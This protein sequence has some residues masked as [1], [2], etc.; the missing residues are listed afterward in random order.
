[1]CLILCLWCTYALCNI[2]IC[3]SNAGSLLLSKFLCF[4]RSFVVVV[5]LK[6]IGSK[7]LFFWSS[8]GFMI[9]LFLSRFFYFYGFAMCIMHL[10][11]VL[12]ALWF[13][14][15]LVQFLFILHCIVAMNFNVF[16][17]FVWKCIPWVNAW[18]NGSKTR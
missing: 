11:V 3:K 13:H 10:F 15:V 17:L 7:V 1:M 5:L 18:Y 9:L 8:F 6:K 2:P 12:F 4:C 16:R 14:C